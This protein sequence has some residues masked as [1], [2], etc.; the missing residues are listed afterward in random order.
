MTY[1]SYGYI[2]RCLFRIF[3]LTSR[4]FVYVLLCVVINTITFVLII[5]VHILHNIVLFYGGCLGREVFNI[6]GFLIYIPKLNKTLQEGEIKVKC[7]KNNFYIKFYRDCKFSQTRMLIVRTIELMIYLIGMIVYDYQNNINIAI[8]NYNDKWN[9]NDNDNDNKLVI[10]RALYYCASIT[11]VLTPLFWLLVLQLGIIDFSKK[12]EEIAFKTILEA[13]K[14]GRLDAIE[15]D[16]NTRK[17]ICSP[18][19]MRIKKKNTKNKR[20]KQKKDKNIENVYQITPLQY[21]CQCDKPSVVSWLVNK[22][23]FI[24]QRNINAVD[25]YQQNAFYLGCKFGSIECI[26][27]LMNNELELM[28]AVDKLNFN[29]QSAL[30]IACKYGHSSVVKNLLEK[31]IFDVKNSQL[32][33]QMTKND[34]STPLHVSCQKGH[35]ECVEALL[36]HNSN[37]DINIL[38]KNNVAP[39]HLS[40]ING[41]GSIS[42]KLLNDNRF[43]LSDTHM[44]HLW[45]LAIKHDQADVVNILLQMHPN[46][47]NLIGSCKTDFEEKMHEKTASE[48]KT[49][50]I[51]YKDSEDNTPLF[52]AAKNNCG[53]IID[54][55]ASAL[56]K[57]AINIC[58]SSNETALYVACING[59]GEAGLALLKCANMDIFF[60]DESSQNTIVMATCQ[61]G[62]KDIFNQLIKQIENYGQGTLRNQLNEINPQTGMGP[63]HIACKY[64]SHEIVEELVKASKKG[65]IDLNQVTTD[66]KTATMVAKQNSNNKTLLVLKLINS[67]EGEFIST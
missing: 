23:G 28:V 4:V 20:S 38:N 39:I 62:S 48:E 11:T 12:K 9:E 52:I 56:D 25:K 1:C 42:V 57:N 30:Y 43:N 22:S 36:Q 60:R 67:F 41:H 29:N 5:C 18:Q 14:L 51:N 45:Y 64:D 53:S 66:G 6:F 7:L 55:I 34:N 54:L 21:A 3:E 37:I 2:T 26:D 49:S 16:F 58:N 8:M 33:N 32:I 15:K 13:I 65:C 61:G 17:H 50:E 10:L 44:E 47:F 40:V 35:L 19:L 46:K 27:Q 63:L 31:E 59:C 24:D